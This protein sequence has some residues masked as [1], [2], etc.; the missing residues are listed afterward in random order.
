MNVFTHLVAI[1]MAPLFFAIFPSTASA[2]ETRTQMHMGTYF[3]ISL[4]S[5]KNEHFQSAFSIIRD[6]DEKLS[7]FKDDSEISRLSRTGKIDASPET[8]RILKEAL[9]YSQMTGG[10]F[11]VTVG[12]LTYDAYGFNRRN[13]K[14]P[15]AKHLAQARS[16]TGYLSVKITDNRVE[17]TQPVRLDLGGIGKGFAVDRVAEYL[18]SKGVTE[19]LIAASGDIRCLHTCTFGI[20]NPFDEF[21]PLGP[22]TSKVKD[23]SLS[24]SGNYRNFIGKKENNHLLDP[25]SGKP[26]QAFASVTLFVRDNHT[27]ADALATA[28][29]VMPPEK[30]QAFLDERKIAYVLILADGRLI[31]SRN[32]EETL[33]FAKSDVP[34]MLQTQTANDANSANSKKKKVR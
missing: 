6:L 15:S 32:L 2:M 26:Q 24:T 10:A 7:H 3:S 16:K 5:G 30:A 12:A 18:K 25:K 22:F 20:D 17:L 21:E 33:D 14:I 27:E 9:Q 13:P 34:D 28:A 19:G 11:D 4:P 29:A 1:L 31:K 8:L 23:L